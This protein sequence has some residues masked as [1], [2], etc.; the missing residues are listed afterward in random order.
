MSFSR[1][2]AQRRGVAGGGAGALGNG[3]E[4]ADHHADEGFGEALL[5]HPLEQLQGLEAGADDVLP[6]PR[7]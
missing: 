1:L 5:L 3:T 6:Q 7:P 2:Q 4:P